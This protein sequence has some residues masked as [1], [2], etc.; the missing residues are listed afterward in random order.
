M[1]QRYDLI[2]VGGSFAGLAC[3]RTAALRGLK[4]AVVDLSKTFDSYYK[5]KDAQTRLKEK[6]DGYQ[7]EIQ[8][9]VEIQVL[10]GTLILP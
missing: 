6:Q 5:T 2:I 9:L 1:I 3:A 10:E 4:V 8:D 7:K